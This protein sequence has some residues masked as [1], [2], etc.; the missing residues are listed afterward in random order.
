MNCTRLEVHVRTILVCTGVFIWNMA[1]SQA[2]TAND[3]T[4]FV[5]K[6]GSSSVLMPSPYNPSEKVSVKIDTVSRYYK[7]TGKLQQRY[8]KMNGVQE[9]NYTEYYSSGQIKATGSYKDGVPEGYLST[10]Y[11]NGQPEKTLRFNGQPEYGTVVVNYWDSTGQHK[12]KN[13]DGYYQSTY[14]EIFEQGELLE[15]GKVK[16]GVRDSVWLGRLNDALAYRR[17][18]RNGKLLE[19]HEEEIMRKLVYAGTDKYPQFPGGQSAMQRFL[20]ARIRYPDISRKMN[21]EGNVQVGFVIDRTGRVVN[22]VILEQPNN[23][24][25]NEV[26]RVINL[27]PRWVPGTQDGAPV[28]VRFILPINFR[29]VDG[30]RRMEGVLLIPTLLRISH[31]IH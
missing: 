17:V 30:G 6:I 20:N 29:L 7:S 5:E 1:S 8:L 14:H 27:M 12:V 28:S 23:E 15:Q 10:W 2:R 4:D 11:S 16:G 3:K 26:I 24:L 9:G 19:N 31:G 13:G 18:Y 25:G 22:P 21:I